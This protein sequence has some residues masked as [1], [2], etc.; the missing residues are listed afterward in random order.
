MSNSVY[1]EVMN[2]V[3]IMVE[4]EKVFMKFLSL[5]KDRLDK[6][7]ALLCQKAVASADWN[8][9]LE[10]DLSDKILEIDED[11][12]ETTG[13]RPMAVIL[14]NAEKLGKIIAEEIVRDPDS[15]IVDQALEEAIE[16][17]NY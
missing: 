1:A 6:E 11:I 17:Y 5:N 14:K 9:V 13:V 15:K 3:R 12:F 16:I 8:E 7:I 10:R 2:I 4:S